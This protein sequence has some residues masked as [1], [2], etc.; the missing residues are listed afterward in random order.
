VPLVAVSNVYVFPGIPRLFSEMLEAH[1]ELFKS[2]A[3]FFRKLLYTKSLE[4][5]FAKAL[6]DIQSRS[7]SCSIGSYPQD[8]SVS[9]S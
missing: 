6:E 8:G 2:N 4:G 7:P 5:D 1:K 9:Y 3:T